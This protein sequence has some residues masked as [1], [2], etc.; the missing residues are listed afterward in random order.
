M[1]PLTLREIV[2]ATGGTFVGD[3]Q[4][5]EYTV[6]SVARD[7]RE[8]TVGALFVCF[9]GERADGHD[10]ADD[11]I[12]RGAVCVLC[13]RE[14]D[15]TPHIRVDSTAAALAQI[16]A[17]Y[18]DKFDIPIIGVVGSVG[19]TT[20]KNMLESVLSQRFCAFVTQGNLNNEIGLPLSILQIGAEHEIAVVE[21]GISDFGEMSRLGAVARP[22]ICVMTRIA[23]AH[24]ENLRDL[25]G[26]LLAKSEVFAHMP[27][28]GLAVLNGDDAKLA[29]FDQRIPRV[30]YGTSP[31]CPYRAEN[32]TAHGTDGV[33]FDVVT[34]TAR[35]SASIPAY[36]AHIPSAALAAVA[37]ADALG[38][39][40][41]EIQRGLTMYATVA[42]RANAVRTGYL[43]VI[44]DCYNANPA[45]M[46]NALKSLQ[47]L[48]PRR[49]AI[50]GDMLELGGDSNELHREIGLLA[51]ECCDVVICCGRCAEFIFKGVIASNRGT[52]VYHFPFRDA[53]L[54]RLPSLLRR[55]DTVLVKA[56]HSM[57]FGEIVSAAME[58]R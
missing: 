22:T 40:A 34:P 8:V 2:D 53:L 37:V 29:A 49:V 17:R 28:D 15:A 9:A 14:I 35:F 4:S 43:T 20:V 5:L 27:P 10:F 55:G 44:D 42:G 24:L 39:D 31:Q 36:G 16:A 50:L 32:I 7:N 45:S 52:E 26:V 54:A 38:M 21:M 46:R 56:S 48:D 11:A 30:L 23:E 19:K 13:E 57:R 3:A 1:K 58:L 47:K 41:D 12:A 6:Q 51:T 25:D 18:R 33:T